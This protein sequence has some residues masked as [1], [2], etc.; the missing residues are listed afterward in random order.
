MCLTAI[1][2]LELQWSYQ[3]PEYQ[4]NCD[5]S[6]QNRQLKTR[7]DP[8]AVHPGPPGPRPRF[9]QARAVNPAGPL[10]ILAELGQE[11]EQAALLFAPR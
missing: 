7:R 1:D 8:Q 6:Q 4:G 5:L 10:G 11:L 2:N 3:I 9:L